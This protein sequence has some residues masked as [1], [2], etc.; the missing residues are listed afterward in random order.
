MCDLC[1]RGPF[2]GLSRHK[3]HR[4]P[5]WEPQHGEVTRFTQWGCRCELCRL[6][7]AKWSRERD[8]IKRAA[9]AACPDCDFRSSPQSVMKHRSR[10]HGP[11]H[12]AEST[13]TTGACRCAMCRQAHR[14]QQGLREL[15]RGERATGAQRCSF[16]GEDGF[17]DLKVHLRTLHGVDTR[18]E[19]G[20]A[21]R[22]AYGCR[23]EPCR[24]DASRR[25]TAM[26]DAA[27][28]RNGQD[29]YRCEDCGRPFRSEGNLLRHQ[30]EK[31]GRQPVL[32][33]KRQPQPRA[34][35]ERAFFCAACGLAF[36]SSESQRAHERSHGIAHRGRYKWR[37]NRARVKWS[38]QPQKATAAVKRLFAEFSLE[39]IEAAFLA[40][41]K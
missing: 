12:G 18:P 5:E 36:F 22:Y 10:V 6:A 39:E 33:P 13:Y 20:T 11:V 9:P 17:I 4:H 30:A 35:R 38:T 25:R 14:R 29:R 26:R 31:H 23:C 7:H 16:C 21:S 27:L 1:G 40:V 24:S 3:R 28:I 34:R 15:R 32:A 37:S 2:R 8:R 19:H 41:R